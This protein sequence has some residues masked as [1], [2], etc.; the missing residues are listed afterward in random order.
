MK[1]RSME[2][3]PQIKVCFILTSDNDNI[4]KITDKLS[5]MPTSVRKK[6]SF[7]VKEF[8]H[9]SWE[10]ST[11]LEACKAVSIQFNKIKQMLSGKEGIINTISKEFELKV[12]FIVIVHAEI[13]DGPEIVLTSEIINYASNINAEIGFDIYYY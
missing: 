1:G 8:A 10:L 13:G 11:G 2:K 7:R 6:D 5:I 12:I 4:D 9:V 3:M